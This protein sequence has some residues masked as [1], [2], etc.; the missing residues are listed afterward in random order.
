M[1]FELNF[2]NF[3]MEKYPLIVFEAANLINLISFPDELVPLNEL[4]QKLQRQQ[5]IYNYLFFVLVFLL[6]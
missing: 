1:S 6:I 3:A 2:N 5:P 4:Q